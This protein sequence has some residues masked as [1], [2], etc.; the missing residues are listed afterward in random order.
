MIKHI[1]LWKPKDQAQ[2]NDKAGNARLIKEKL[3][4]LKT[5]VPGLMNLEVGIDFSG[6][7]SSA[8]VALYAE[9][10]SREALEEYQDHP[11]HLAVSAFVMG[12]RSERRLA[13]YEV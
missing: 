12:V 11:E 3:E 2:G 7:D 13:D 6:T 9:F 1:V 10:A 8:D 4:A 5:K